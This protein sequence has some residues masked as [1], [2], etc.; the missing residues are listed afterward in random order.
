MGTCDQIS[1]ILTKEWI[2]WRRNMCSSICQLIIP[3]V[4]AALLL[5]IS[6]ASYHTDGGPNYE[7]KLAGIDL[8]NTE[9]TM[10]GLPNM[11]VLFKEMFSKATGKAV[12]VSPASADITK[13]MM[14][15]FNEN[16]VSAL[17]F[18]SEADLISYAAS[19]INKTED[20]TFVNLTCGLS[21][22]KTGENKEYAYKLLI[23]KYTIQDVS[24]N[25]VDTL[26]RYPPLFDITLSIARRWRIAITASW[27][28][29][30]S[31]TSRLWPTPAS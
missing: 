28:H 2:Y 26:Q 13:R 1:A 18:E 25:F 16:G 8:T 5:L 10:G 15:Y 12:G 29:R 19:P 20:G 27:G 24:D 21:F 31:F 4:G 22:T 23:D 9:L 7:T 6:S 30:E 11:A 3:F 17:A 14:E